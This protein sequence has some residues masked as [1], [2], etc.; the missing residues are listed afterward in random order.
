MTQ[1]LMEQFCPP[2]YND[3]FDTRAHKLINVCMKNLC[4][5]NMIWTTVTRKTTSLSA[6]T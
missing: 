2:D 4:Y 5:C 3:I 1:K 6:K